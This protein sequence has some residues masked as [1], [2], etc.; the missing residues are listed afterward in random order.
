MDRDE[1]IKKLCLIGGLGGL[2]V[3]YLLLFLSPESD[4][5][6]EK[7]ANYNWSYEK[8]CENGDFEVAH[9]ILAKLQDDVLEEKR[10]ERHHQ[11]KKE[12]KTHLFK[13][14]EIVVDSVSIL[15]HEQYIQGLQDKGRI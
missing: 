4:Y 1:R 10:W 15:D 11:I 6:K 5:E 14:D 9:N 7:K 12:K 3:F 8:A 2:F 13:D